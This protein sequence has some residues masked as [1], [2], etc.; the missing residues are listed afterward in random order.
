M[1]KTNITQNS[2][3]FKL[4]IDHL[5]HINQSLGNGFDIRNFDF[6]KNQNNIKDLPDNVDIKS[7]QALQRL[8]RLVAPKGN[9]SENK[10]QTLL[11]LYNVGLHSAYHIAS[12]PQD[13]FVQK[14]S[15][16]FS[17]EKQATKLHN[18]AKASKNHSIRKYIEITQN[19]N[20]FYCTSRFNNLSDIAD[21]NFSNLPSYEELF[22]G[23]NF[24]EYPDYRREFGQKRA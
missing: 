19:K 1:K 13:Q 5:D 21:Q 17:S 14:Y 15:S 24:C 20:P 11:N 7:L 3:S 2:N 23:L 8:A 4:C 16:C 6:H 9:L 10:K 22:G 18:A 12:I